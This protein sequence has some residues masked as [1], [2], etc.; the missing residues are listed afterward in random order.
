MSVSPRLRL[1]SAARQTLPSGKA[2]PYAIGAGAVV[3]SFAISAL[4]NAK[5]AKNAERENPPAGRFVDVE[6][7]RLHYIERGKGQP[8]VL[9]HGNGSMVQDFESSGL[10]ALASEQ[11]RVSA[12]GAVAVLAGDMTDIGGEVADEIGTARVCRRMPD[13][14][15]CNG[16][17]GHASKRQ[18]FSHRMLG[19]QSGVHLAKNARLARLLQACCVVVGTLCP[20]GQAVTQRIHSIYG[21]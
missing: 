3:A 20:R 11:F 17:N 10:I 6:G 5:L 13:S 7:V 21:R 2:L 14:G 9:L 4:V 19:S 12:I 1:G 15:T 16:Q 8:L 18:R